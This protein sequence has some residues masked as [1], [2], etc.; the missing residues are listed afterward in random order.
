MAAGLINTKL[1]IPPI[2][3]GILLQTGLYSLNL[4]VMDGRPNIA[5]LGQTTIFT[6]LEEGLGLS[7]NLSAAIVALVVLAFI[8]LLLVAFLK[9]EV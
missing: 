9:T 1:N 6:P 8:I 4:R 5:L 2:L 3:T 7:K